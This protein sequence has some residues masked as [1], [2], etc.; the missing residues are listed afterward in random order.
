M[1]NDIVFQI[2]QLLTNK[3][4]AIAQP[5]PMFMQLLPTSSL[6]WKTLFRRTWPPFDS[7]SHGFVCCCSNSSFF[8]LEIE[9]MV[10][11]VSLEE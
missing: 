7:F 6:E 5:K 4:A 10:V 1:P 2:Q 11:V 3:L 8:Y 9:P